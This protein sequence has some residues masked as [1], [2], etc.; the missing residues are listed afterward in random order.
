MWLLLLQHLLARQLKD[1]EF[2]WN[3]DKVLH[4]YV[5]NACHQLPFR[6]KLAA[7]QTQLCVKH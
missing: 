4:Q 2:V 5:Y 3:Y 1:C 6:H 7:N